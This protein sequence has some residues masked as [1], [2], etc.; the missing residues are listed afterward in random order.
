MVNNTLQKLT[1][2]MPH[3]PFYAQKYKKSRLRTSIMT[4]IYFARARLCTFIYTQ[5]AE[6]A[7]TGMDMCRHEASRLVP[8]GTNRRWPRSTNGDVRFLI[9]FHDI[10]NTLYRQTQKKT[11]NE[12]TTHLLL[13]VSG[14]TTK[15]HARLHTCTK[16]TS[17]FISARITDWLKH[18]PGRDYSIVE[19]ASTVLSGSKEQY[20][21]DD[22]NTIVKS[23]YREREKRDYA[24]T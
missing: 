8:H 11:A 6:K 9:C 4:E 17:G 18:C 7:H 20:C 12:T 5:R 19:T 1:N 13:T 23:R 10:L 3:F 21:Q 15:S 16:A 14:A 22:D 24:M 2:A